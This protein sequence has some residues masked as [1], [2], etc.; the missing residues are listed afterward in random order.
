M[1]EEIIKEL[2]NSMEETIECLRREFSKVRTGRASL[3]LLDGIKVQY[4]GEVTPLNQVATLSVPEARLITIQPWDTKVIGEIEKA[5]QKSGLGLTPIN[6]GKLIRISIPNLTEERRQ[7]LIKVVRRM[8]EDCKVSL[9]N[10]RRETNNMLKEMKKEISEDD[11]FKLQ[12]EVQ[13][14]TDKY[15]KKSD[16]TLAAKEKE[17]LEI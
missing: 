12:D 13:K 10:T 14:I 11:L 15:V 9:R 16:E 6:D 7:E 1:K 4:Y 2:E 8:T 17:V 5:I 3:S